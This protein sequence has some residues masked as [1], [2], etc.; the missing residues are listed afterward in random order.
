MWKGDSHS[1]KVRSKT[2]PSLLSFN[3][4]IDII[5]REQIRK[6]RILSVPVNTLQQSSRM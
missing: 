6:E 5:A 4:G 1:S 2:S 3:I